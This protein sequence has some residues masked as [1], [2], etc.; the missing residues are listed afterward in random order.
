MTVVGAQSGMR[1]RER[2]ERESAR[3]R[4]R[5]RRRVNRVKKNIGYINFQILREGP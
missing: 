2:D 4:K 3:V 5:T 1:V